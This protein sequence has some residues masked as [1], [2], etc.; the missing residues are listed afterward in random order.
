M[1]VVDYSMVATAGVRGEDA[2][3]SNDATL[4]WIAHQYYR[5][6][7]RVRA[8][9]LAAIAA[10]A[11]GAVAGRRRGRPDPTV[12]IREIASRWYPT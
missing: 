7:P 6:N 3:P 10:G 5:N 2:T 4:N 9:M 11:D 12:A 1:D 8:D